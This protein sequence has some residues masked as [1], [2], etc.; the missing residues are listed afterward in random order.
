MLPLIKPGLFAGGTIV[1]IWAFTELGVPVDLRLPAGHVGA[2]FDGLR[3]HIGGNPFPYALVAVML[4]STCLLYAIGK[5]LFGRQSYAMMA[6]AT[7]AGGPRRLP[8]GSSWLCTALFAGVTFIAV[9]PHIGVARR[10][11][12]RLVP[13]NPPG[14]LHPR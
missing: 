1:F 13:D 4:V 14:W 6:K 9:L 5:G 3:A 12:H 8:A 2:D 7:S 11:F 10:V